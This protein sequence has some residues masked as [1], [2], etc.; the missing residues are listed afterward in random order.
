MLRN[1]FVFFSVFFLSGMLFAQGTGEAITTQ[2]SEPFIS[3]AAHIDQKFGLDAYGIGKPISYYEEIKLPKGNQYSVPVKSVGEN[4]NEPVHAV[5]NGFK[6]FD[7]DQ[8]QFLISDS[9]EVVTFFRVNDTLLT[10][11]LP[12]KRKDYFIS[13]RYKGKVAG[14]LKIEVFKPIS[15]KIAIVNLTKEP[16]DEEYLEEFLNEIYKQANIRLDIISNT[17]FTDTLFNDQFI[18][19]NPS[20]AND[21]YT[22]QM[23]ELRDR[24]FEKNPKATKNAYYLFIVPG[25]VDTKLKGYMARNHAIGFIKHTNEPDMFHSIARELG[26]GI[27]MLDHFWNETKMEQ[28]STLNLMDRNGGSELM[29]YQWVD[30]RH[31]SNSYSFYDGDED[32]KTNNGM[33]AYYFWEENKDGFIE[34]NKEHP[35]NK[36]LR[37]F[38]KNYL[39]YHLNINDRLFKVLYEWNNYFLCAWHLIAWGILMVTWILVRI[40]R[41][42]KRK[43]NTI[44]PGFFKRKLSNWTINLFF[45]STMLFTYF[46]INSL[47]KNFEV[48]SGIIADFHKQ[49]YKVVMDNVLYNINLKYDVEDEPKSEI[50]IKRGDDWYMKRKKKVLYFDVFQNEKN[51][52]SLCKFV[53]ESDS[54]NLISLNFNSEAESHY[55]VFNFK[56]SVNV[57]AYQ[58][59]FNHLGVDVTDKLELK[60][61]AKRILVFVNGYRPT[62]V[63]HSFEDNFR[64]IKKKGLEFPNSSNL[65]YDFDRF[66][67]WRPW[68]EIDLR[69]QKRINP[70]ETY[71]ADGHFSVSTSNY[72]SLLNFTH[73][74][75]IYP[76]RCKSR[77]RHV[78]WKTTKNSTGIFGDKKVNT[79]DLLPVKSNK[80]GFKERYR[81]GKIAAKNLLLMFNEIPNK[82]YNDTIYL[83]AHSMGY[84]YSLG[85][86][87]EL[88]GK[89]NFGGFYIMAAENAGQGRVNLEE[90]KE[91]WQYGSRMNDT[92]KEAPCLQDGVAPQVCAKGLSEANRVYIPDQFYRRKG[93]FDSHFVGY[94][95][96][97]FDIEQG[98]KGAIKQR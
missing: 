98:K 80:K 42:K 38:K 97:I 29:Y 30:L 61:A 92:S 53:D 56:D 24:Y 16:I 88:R 13:V 85:M 4:K 35:L 26:H 63:G 66:D 39:S 3:F 9:S 81:N 51:E 59:V 37:P 23:R 43:R 48:K 60:D 22:R 55:C 65:I 58:K 86:I 31:S 27:G 17:S 79:Y 18:F 14:K 28:G 6:Q 20:T 64:D 47:L 54:L 72:K 76:K 57:L 11:L 5:L 7:I 10:V 68:Q 33:I 70:S 71:Y 21:R 84:A 40:L 89:I 78:C 2:K 50:M 49:S 1:W 73:L 96:W 8:L 82:S 45:L 91:V 62:S 36:I 93:F 12:K 77:I 25:F 90:W 15:E 19:N 83:V 67:Y 44:K 32:V 87:E 41:N 52:F 75:T 94:Y 34:L 69:F 46:I 74:T 95:T